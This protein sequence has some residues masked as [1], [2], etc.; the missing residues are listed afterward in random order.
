MEEPAVTSPMAVARRLKKYCE[1]IESVGRKRSPMPIPM[2]MAW[3]RM[4]CQNSV[5]RDVMN[6]LLTVSIHP[7]FSTWLVHIDS[8]KEA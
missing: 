7:T 6:R 5:H 4:T 3:A 2:P 1:M 8:W